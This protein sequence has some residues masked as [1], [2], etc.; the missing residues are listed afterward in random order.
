VIDYEAFI[1]IV[2]EDADIGSEAAER[3]SRAVLETLGERIAQGEGRDLAGQLPPELAPSIA[4]TTPAEGFDVDE[5]VRRVAEREGVD[6]AT[7]ER[8]ARAVFTALSR[9]VDRR[10]Y[11]QMAAELSKDYSPLLAFGPA[12]QTVSADVF[13]QRVAER[14]GLDPDDARKATDAV[15]ETLAERIA[16]GEVRDLI[17]RLP[18]ALHE[19]LK[20]GAA[21]NG[22]NA[23]RMGVDVFLA[24]VAEREGVGVEDARDHVRAV[25]LTL[26]EAV[27]DQEFIDVTVE[28]PREYESVL[29]R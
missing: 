10:E 3:A 1:A 6:V 2:A 16:A 24:R 20:R 14:T 5:F 28:L 29:P 19:P 7:A 18:I 12:I 15:L 23:M 9:A 25:I 11:E 22:G 26:R 8:D 13:V 21:R 4:T 27:G 17:A